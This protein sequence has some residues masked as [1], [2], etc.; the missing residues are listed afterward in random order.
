VDC[1]GMRWDTTSIYYLDLSLCFMSGCFQGC[2][3]CPY[4]GYPWM[5]HVSRYRMF[6]DGPWGSGMW[7]S[8]GI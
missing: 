8:L 1:D 6:I 2:L 3:G 5:W 7:R 4:V